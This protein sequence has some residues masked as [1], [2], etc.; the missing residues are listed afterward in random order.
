L[1]IIF[2]EADIIYNEALHPVI[3]QREV[4]HVIA[5]LL[6]FLWCNDALLWSK[7]GFTTF[8]GAYILDQVVLYLEN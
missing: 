8:F 1:K 3:R 5:R 4:A 7:E 2:R 6:A